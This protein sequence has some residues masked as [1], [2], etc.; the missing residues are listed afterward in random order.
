MQHLAWIYNNFTWNI[1]CYLGYNRQ[2]SRNKNLDENQINYFYSDLLVEARR[3]PASFRICVLWVRLLLA[4]SGGRVHFL[5]TDSEAW[6]LP[7]LALSPACL[8]NISRLEIIKMGSKRHNERKLQG[9][10]GTGKV[11][12]VLWS[13]PSAAYWGMA[14]SWTGLA[15]LLKNSQ[16]KIKYGS[17]QTLLFHCE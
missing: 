3:N 10:G 14:K 15:S 17:F 2:W 13:T 16:Q 4:L 11:I 8:E 6:N 5:C 1:C 7:Y 12:F 9:G